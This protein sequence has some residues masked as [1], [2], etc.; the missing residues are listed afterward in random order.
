MRRKKMNKKYE[1]TKEGSTIFGAILFKEEFSKEKIDNLKFLGYIESSAGFFSL[2]PP[3]KWEKYKTD[4]IS[5]VR[6]EDKKWD[7]CS[8][9]S[10]KLEYNE[11]D[12]LELEK[13]YENTKS[14]K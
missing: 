1:I 5:F 2:T 8:F 4:F 13:L 10:K 6:F 14:N 11:E 7:W 9:S 12:I 3:F